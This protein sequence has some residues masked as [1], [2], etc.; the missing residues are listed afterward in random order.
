[1]L[2]AISGSQGSG[3]AQPLYSKILTP[4]GWTTMGELKI[5]DEICTPSGDI[6]RVVDIFPQGIKPV[7][8]ITMH[9]G[10][11]TD[12]CIDHLWKCFYARQ[13]KVK[14]KSTY[15]KCNEIVDTN[16]IINYLNKHKVRR[17]NNWGCGISI[18]VISSNVEVHNTNSNPIIPPYL[19]GCLIGDGS[20]SCGSVSFTSTDQFIID[21]CSSLLQPPYEFYSYGNNIDYVIRGSGGGHSSVYTNNLK[22]LGLYG[23]RSHE[24]FIP[25]EYK[26]LNNSDKWELIRGLMDTDGTVCKRGS[27]ISF[28]TTSFTLAND[29]RELVWS[30]GCTASINIHHPHYKNSNGTIV[31]GKTAYEVIVKHNNPKLFFSLPRKLQRC[32]DSH[33][34]GHKNGSIEL[35]RRIVDITYKCDEEVQ[36]IL[37]DHPD[38]LY[39]TDDYIVTHNTTTLSRIKELGFPII[40]RKTSRSILSDWNVTLTEINSSPELTIRFQNEILKRKHEDELFAI[41]S[42][43]IYF[44][45]RT[46]GDLFTYCLLTLGSNNE[47]SSFINEYYTQCIKYQQQYASVFYLKAGHFIPVDDGVRGFNVH[48]S[49]LADLAMLDITTQMTK[50][51]KLNVIDTPCLEQRLS[52]I[53]NHVLY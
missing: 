50:P 36:C 40:E 2:V 52:I 19:L 18:P 17:S 37:I 53:V 21:K 49:R 14:G 41:Q 47:Y 6:S 9:D 25:V 42:S 44:G 5:G 32:K 22:K 51:G 23:K 10:S 24:K 33:Y 34:E 28:T 35:K 15:I 45:E 16:F 30:V 13:T 4:S 39:I 31:P 3:K 12:A 29:F 11:Q 20:F 48:Y 38:H 7:Y 43:D 1:M 27:T 26:Q 8:T 46:Y